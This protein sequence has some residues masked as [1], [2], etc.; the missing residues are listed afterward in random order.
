MLIA[1]GVL[2]LIGGALMLIAGAIIRKQE[3]HEPAPWERARAWLRR[4]LR[5]SPSV[6]GSATISGT[7]SMEARGKVRPGPVEPTMTN[8][9]RL[10][11]LERFVDLLDADLDEA[12]NRI[13]QK[14]S[15]VTEAAKAREQAIRDEQKQR[16]DERRAAVRPALRMQS[17]G[18]GCILVG[19]VL[20]LISTV[21]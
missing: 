18:G 19:I 3:L 11:R 4:L 10:Q 17:A 9:Q 13:S 15:D 14:A 6:E 21:V 12:H 2:Q 5:R 7:I 20:A 8:E 1:G 16:D